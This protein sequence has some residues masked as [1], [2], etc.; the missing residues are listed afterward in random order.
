MRSAWNFLSIHQIHA[1]T[2]L[3]G[4]V[5]HNLK[6]YTELDTTVVLPLTEELKHLNGQWWT[7]DD[8]G[9]LLSR[10]PT[11]NPVGNHL[12]DLYPKKFGEPQLSS[13]S[14]STPLLLPRRS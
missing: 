9:G 10:R 12:L 14:L 5:L 4:F 7:R 8:V 3:F 6:E 2:Y 11:I 13:L 1:S